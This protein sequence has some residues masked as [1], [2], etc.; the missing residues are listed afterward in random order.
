M[1]GKKNHF[2][3]TLIHLEITKGEKVN[4]T[5]EKTLFSTFFP[6]SLPP[7]EIRTI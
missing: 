7:K 2:I 3:L 1:E 6:P 5:A 4:G